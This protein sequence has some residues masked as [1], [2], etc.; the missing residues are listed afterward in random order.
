MRVKGLI[1]LALADSKLVKTMLRGNL[2][3]ELYIG[4]LA[5]LTQQA[6]EKYLKFILELRGASYPRTHDMNVLISCVESLGISVPDYIKQNSMIL[7]LWE[8]EG[9]Y[10]CN[11]VADV[12][13]IKG[14][15]DR[16]YKDIVD[17]IKKLEKV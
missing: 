10:N 15:N 17:M 2:Y 4:V 9:R 12:R 8:T 1:L 6:I 11:F 13:F 5:F 16:I 3:D 14:I 7:R